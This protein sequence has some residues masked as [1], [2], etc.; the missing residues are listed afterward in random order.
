MQLLVTVG[1]IPPGLKTG[2]NET[3]ETLKVHL[4]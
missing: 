2:F 4:Q 3:N 1:K